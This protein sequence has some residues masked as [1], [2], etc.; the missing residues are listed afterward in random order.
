MSGDRLNAD[1][2][3]Y[4]RAAGENGAPPTITSDHLVAGLTPVEQLLRVLG[5]AANADDS[6]DTADSVAAQAERDIQM[7]ADAEAFAAEDRQASAAM[8]GV[9]GP[10][11]VTQMAQQIPQLISGIAGA[12]TGALGGAL[13]PLVQIPQQLAQ[14]ATQT[15]TAVSPDMDAAETPLMDDFG[16]DFGADLGADFGADFGG[17]SGGGGGAGGFG[18]T[19][20]TALLGPPPIPSAS[21][22][23]AAAPAIPMPATSTPSAAPS[24][25]GGMSGVPMIPPGAMQGGATGDRDTKSDTKRVSVPPVPNGSPVQG[26]L[27]AP[28]ITP[29][30]TTTI[31]GK[32]VATKRI[33]G[34]DAGKA[35]T[36][37]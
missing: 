20:P 16:A 15:G 32:P 31:E 14:A 19:A 18:G 4:G 26:R 7:I 10:D 36:A 22:A 8:T 11:Q 34:L 1:T 30:V 24:A 25:A 12:I 3:L 28:Q 23:P 13:Q 37:G 29:A 9:E 5:L 27:T 17:G 6:G 21:T 2:D 33:I 35:D